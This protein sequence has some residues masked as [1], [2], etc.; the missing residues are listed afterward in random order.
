M[1]TH[2]HQSKPVEEPMAA[3]TQDHLPSSPAAA[4]AA[5]QP[6]AAAYIRLVIE[7]LVSRDTASDTGRIR[8]LLRRRPRGVVAASFPAAVTAAL[9]DLEALYSEGSAPMAALAR[10]AA[11]S[12]RAG[13]EERLRRAASQRLAVEGPIR[14]LAAGIDAAGKRLGEEEATVR[15]TQRRLLL[16][17]VAVA[18]EADVSAVV[19]LVERLARAQGAEAGLAVA[20]EAM[21]VRHRRLLL[22]REAAEVAELTEMS[23]LEDI[24]QVARSSKEDDQLLRE[25]DGRLR[26]DVTVLIECLYSR[27]M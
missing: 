4:A 22:Q 11:R 9:D 5:D 13:H 16:L 3:A 15:R 26:A 17:S 18:E 27:L 7:Q 10:D 6:Q 23:A 2:T 24:P 12:R 8:L 21:K 20:M 14:D 1:A 19:S 25:A